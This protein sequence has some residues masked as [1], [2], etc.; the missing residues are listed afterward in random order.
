MM[1][2]MKMN[3]FNNDYNEEEDELGFNLV[4]D[5]VETKDNDDDNGDDDDDYDDELMMMMMMMMVMM[6]MMMINLVIDHVESKDTNC[7][8]RLLTAY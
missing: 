3:S 5:H 1:M 2:M 8:E 7:V 4:I 6:M